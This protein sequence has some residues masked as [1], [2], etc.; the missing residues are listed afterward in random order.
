MKFTVIIPA[1]Y[2]S[3]RLPAKPLMDIAGKPMIQHVY[4][5]AVLSSASRVVIATDHAE[6]EAVATKFGAEVV[7]TAQH[8]ESGTDRLHEVVEKL[9]YVDDEIVV[10]VQGDEPLIP[11]AVIDQ[12][13]TLIAAHDSAS[14]ATLCEQII[15]AAQLFDPNVVKVVFDHFA[16]ALYFSRAP[17]PWSRDTFQ[18]GREQGGHQA[19]LPATAQY[20][21]HIGIYAYRVSLLQQ[22]VTWPVSALE[23]TEKLEQLRA[24]ENGAEIR[25]AQACAAI[26]AGV[27]TAADLDRVRHCI[28]QHRL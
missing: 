27:D 23:R 4:E 21:R 2:A 26:P 15:D 6:I 9:G 7:M 22:F 25:I 17:V 18:W 12:V 20:Y 24:M 16:R 1:R 28:S 8:H 14:V 3:T 5:R 11:S 10:N 13:A 19:A